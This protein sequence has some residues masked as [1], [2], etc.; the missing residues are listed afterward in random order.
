MH[1]KLVNA[2]D[3]FRD[4]SEISDREAA[5]IARND[6]IDIAIDLNGFTQTLALVFLVIVQHAF[7]SIT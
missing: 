1:K 5:M 7:R 4:L 3:V 6:N 2:F